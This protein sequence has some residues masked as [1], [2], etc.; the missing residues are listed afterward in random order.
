MTKTRAAP[1]S[2]VALLLAHHTN[3]WIGDP[4]MN[5]VVAM[6]AAAI[7][8]HIIERTR[9]QMHTTLDQVFDAAMAKLLEAT[10]TKQ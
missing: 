6:T 4:A 1:P 9:E 10:E 7:T 3:E 5:F 8:G 2:E